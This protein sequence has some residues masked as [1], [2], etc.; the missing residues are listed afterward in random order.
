MVR[1]SAENGVLASTIM[2]A[3]RNLVSSGGAPSWLVR[4]SFLSLLLAIFAYL[5]AYYVPVLPVPIK[6]QFRSGEP[7]DIPHDH[8]DVKPQLRLAPGSYHRTDARERFKNLSPPHREG[9]GGNTVAVV[10]NWSRFPNVRRIVSLLCNS[11][12]DSF[13]T[14]NAYWCGITAQNL[15]YLVRDMSPPF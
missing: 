3:K 14:R 7:P 11:E 6:P 15:T 1:I 10:L 2:M 5:L 8:H 9:G 12:L 13:M 4:Y